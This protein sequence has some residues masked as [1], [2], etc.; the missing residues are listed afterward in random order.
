VE[1]LAHQELVT[2]YTA[3]GQA[4]AKVIKSM[5][6][7]NGIPVTLKSE[8]IGELY[9]VAVNGLGAIDIIVPKDLADIA[10]RL[11]EIRNRKNARS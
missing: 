5:L 6:E 2:V 11:I 3:Y 1:I 10:R 8:A 9:G 4:E 7:A